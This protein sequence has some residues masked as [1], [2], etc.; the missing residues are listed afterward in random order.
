MS[1]ITPEWR[2]L[3]AEAA[4]ESALACL[5]RLREQSAHVELPEFLDFDGAGQLLGR[6]AKSLRHYHQQGKFV[7]AYRPPGT[8]HV[9]ALRFRRADLLGWYEPVDRGTEA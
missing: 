6:S 7:P 2:Q 5:R 1:D 8:S 3:V 9:T 4:R